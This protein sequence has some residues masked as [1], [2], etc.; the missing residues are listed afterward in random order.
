MK[1]GTG[2]GR[3]V[4]AGAVLTL[5]A[6]SLLGRWIFGWGSSASANA[7]SGASSICSRKPALGKTKA[8]KFD[9]MDPTLH[10]SR[11][12]L[13]AREVYAGSGRNVFASYGEDQPGHT[14]R[15]RPRPQPVPPSTPGVPP[16]TIGLKFFGIAM[17]SGLPRQACLSQEGDIF[18]GGEGDM[19][20]GRYQLLRIGNST[21]DVQDLLGNNTYT[22]RLQR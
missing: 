9:P 7:R 16:A 1:V 20:D 21:V 2:D 12:A 8:N 18:I 15:P 13:T 10:F 14:L 4:A 3:R 11:L 5:L 17:I 19:V 6:V 22:L